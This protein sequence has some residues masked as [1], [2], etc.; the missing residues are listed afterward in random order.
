MNVG[1]I[2]RFRNRDWVVLASDDA[3]TVL[4][5]PLTG[6]SEDAVG[7]HRRLSELIAYSIPTE[8][9]EP[10][11][12]P[13]PDPS[14]VADAQ[15]VHLL[16]QAARLL[17]REGATPFRSL[18]RISARPRTYQLVPLMM[19]L[20]L[21]PVRLLIADD[22]G[23][24]K[25][26]EAGLIVRELWD[27]GEIRRV[28][29][30]CPPYLSDWW[31]M[32]LEEKFHLEPVVIGPGTVGRLERE[33][34]PGRTLYEHFPVQ[35]ISIDF[36][37]TERNR[38]AFLLKAPELV[39]V[40]EAHG[41]TPA[42]SGDRHLR[43]KLVR[44]LAEDPHRHL[45]LLTATP[46][47]GIPG[48]FQKLLGLLKPEFETWDFSNLSEMQRAKLARHFVQ[49]TR[50]DIERDWED[51]PC[52]PTRK[53]VEVT[54]RLSPAYSELFY[55]VHR[56]CGRIV[57]SGEQLEWN[58]RRMR[59]W[60][61]LALLRCVMSS[62]R[63]AVVAL[64]NRAGDGALEAEVDEEDMAD[65]VVE[66]SEQ[67]AFDEAPTPLLARL[68]GALEPG[69]R[70][71]LQR[72]ARKAA[73]ITREDDTKLRGCLEAV[74]SLLRE[75]HHPIIWCYYVETAE[76]VAE[77]IRS[78]LV[79]EFPD[80][81]VACIT[82]RLDDDERRMKVEELMA[83][84][85]R[86]LVATD[87]LSEGVNLQK[88]FTAVLHY[89]LPWNPNRLEQREGRVDRFGQERDEVKAVRYYGAD[90]PVDAA[91]LRVLLNKAEEIRRA[92]GTY[93]PV[94]E[95]AQR[96]VE[97]LVDVLFRR[98]RHS[99][100]L[101]TALPLQ[102][103]GVEELHRT[104]ELDA[105]RERESR[106]RFAQRALKPQ[107][108][109]R[110]LEATDAVLGDADAVQNFVLSVAKRLQL[111]IWQS[112]SKDVWKVGTAT[113]GLHGLPESIREALPRSAADTWSI[114]FTSPPS[115]GAT[116]LGRNH[117]FVTALARYVFEQALEGVDEAVAARCGAL[118]TRAVRKLTTLLLLR[119]RFFLGE[120]GRPPLLAEEVLVCGFEGFSER[121][122]RPAEALPL[123]SAES[124]S[125]MPLEEKRDLVSLVLEE[126]RAALT[127]DALDHPLRV[128]LAER[129]EELAE[130][131]RRVRQSVGQYIR[132]FSVRS[133]WPPD[134]LGLLVLQP[135]VGG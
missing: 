103:D 94:P 7:V 122:L 125:N 48:A 99:L 28:A 56:F 118:R 49:R 16:W 37:K 77:A 5:R 98:R 8:R 83:E 61:A 27:R 67:L 111:N 12:F 79:P 45:L 113:T 36:I 127:A 101:Q 129:G 35:V 74:R 66:P 114:T 91:V 80:L 85:R 65:A 17:L 18:G 50:A 57:E 63:A 62:P 13:L 51:R 39:I 55:D 124:T 126:V 54:Y 34:P 43:Y 59:W 24:G 69:E 3:D 133:H 107:E 95:N 10:S 87:C 38:P 30:L 86:V 120:A 47:S 23:V 135:E 123:L 21:D 131:H 84:H 128:I 71:A 9:I 20:R 92:L 82:G 130:S 96:V 112:K 121:W 4:L 109:R 115:E 32:E 116:Y 102:Q 29:V 22:V 78:E 100:A 1:S 11:A 25:T 105:Q 119:P 93:V 14:S 81:Q 31:R 6:V 33:V 15:S 42:E 72:F 88:G 73:E 52:F 108:V 110:E 90:N 44:E 19:A 60:G 117:P 70:E 2:V 26:V 64:R 68:E 41:A 53:P 97:A 58:R 132:G 46:H 75:G 104:W 89:D 40:D 76:Y 106:T 134:V